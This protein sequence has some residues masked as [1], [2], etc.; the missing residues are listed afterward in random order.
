[1]QAIKARGEGSVRITGKWFEVKAVLREP[2]TINRIGLTIGK[3]FAKRAVDR[4]LVKRL[5]REECRRSQI[6]Q[7]EGSVS[8]GNDV[9]FRLITDIS[10]TAAL[11]CERKLLKQK[12]TEDARNL[13]HLLERRLS[14]N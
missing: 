13:L 2:Q 12:L 6:F 1:M 9:V 7:K 10:C 8:Y 5:I 11:V 3:R 4:N 14:S